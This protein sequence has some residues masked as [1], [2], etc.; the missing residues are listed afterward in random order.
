MVDSFKHNFYENW[1]KFS[2]IFK[3]MLKFKNLS[4]VATELKIRDPHRTA[5]FSPIAHSSACG[6]CTASVPIIDTA[7]PYRRTRR[8]LCAGSARSR[9][10]TAG[11]S[12]QAARPQKS[13]ALRGKSL[14]RG[15]AAQL[16]S[17]SS[18]HVCSLCLRERA[19]SRRVRV[20]CKGGGGGEGRQVQ[21]R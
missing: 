2:Q 6:R 4:K 11:R 9:L 7:G 14:L 5:S 13:E 17:P 19:S 8:R 10:S 1:L 15:T 12:P 18:F 16:S 20:Q 3:V 21:V